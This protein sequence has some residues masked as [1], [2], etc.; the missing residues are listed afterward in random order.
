MTAVC[1]QNRLYTAGNPFHIL[2]HIHQQTL[3]LPIFPNGKGNLFKC[4]AV[5]LQLLLRLC[6]QL[7]V[8]LQ[9]ILGF[10]Y[11]LFGSS[12]RLCRSLF[13]P[14]MLHKCATQ[15]ACKSSNCCCTVSNAT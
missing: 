13:R 10:R 2:F 3:P 12:L 7:I 1:P 6:L 9:L 4:G 8:A 15:R 14:L 11:S 5:L